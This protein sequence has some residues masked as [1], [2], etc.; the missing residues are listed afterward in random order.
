M[1]ISRNARSFAVSCSSTLA[2][3]HHPRLFRHFSTNFTKF[4]SRTRYRRPIV[5]KLDSS[6]PRRTATVP[7]LS[8]LVCS[9]LAAS[10][11]L[12]LAIGATELAVEVPTSLG[13]DRVT[14]VATGSSL[15]EPLYIGWADEYH[16]QNPLVVI[17]YLPQGTGESAESILAGSGDLGGGD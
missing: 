7:R 16:K 3:T 2:E 10:L 11:S 14:L 5:R 1:R 4:R 17:R 13:Q 15:P 6:S 12:T 8:R 9:T